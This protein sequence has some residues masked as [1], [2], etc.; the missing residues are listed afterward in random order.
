MKKSIVYLMLVLL[1]TCTVAPV[2]SAATANRESGGLLGL[3][4]G[5]CFGIR[6]AAASNDG[7]D[8][9]WREWGM[10]IPLFGIVVNVLNGLDG[11]SGITTADLASQYGSNY[12]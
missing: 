2:A 1:T 9:H 3:V 7:K 5:C 8:L 10:L 11:M 4:A 6:S 12:Y